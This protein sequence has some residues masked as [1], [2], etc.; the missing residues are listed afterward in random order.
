MKRFIAIIFVVMFA[1]LML[2]GCGSNGVDSN[3]S[4]ETDTSSA[5]V[6]QTA[7]SESDIVY[8]LTMVAPDPTT[9]VD[10]RWW[11]A[12]RKYLYN[13]S[14]GRIIINEYTGGA[15]VA[16]GDE[17]A[18]VQNG[19]ADMAKVDSEWAAGQIVF[20]EA[21]NL[22]G[23]VSWPAAMQSAQLQMALYE[24]FE[25][26]QNEWQGIKYLFPIYGGSTELMTTKQ[27]VYTLDDAKGLNM[28]EI[29][30]YASEAAKLLGMVPL[31]MSITEQADALNKGIA[32]G[33]E[34]NYNATYNFYSDS[35]KYC[36]QTGFVQPSCAFVCINENTLAALPDDLQELFDEEHMYDAMITINYLRDK[37]DIEHKQDLIDMGVE[38]YELP[39]QELETWKEMVAP[40]RDMWIEDAGGD[41]AEIM[42]RLLELTD[43]YLYDD[44]LADEAEAILTEWESLPIELPNA[45]E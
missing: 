11:N 15:L 33:I 12:W 32:D 9:G 21:V 6:A 37:G 20:N 41:S 36:T 14:D 27:P 2:V 22:P 23:T 1:L 10:V 13:A 8:E 43:D 19:L 16:T 40:V 18:A 17:L 3:S 39:E 35:I 26:M 38:V 4:G 31:S 29:G 24:E 44:T 30:T 7:T 45:A 25:S 34:L 28:L 42:E 5:S